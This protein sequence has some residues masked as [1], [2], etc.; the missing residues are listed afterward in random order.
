[1]QIQEAVLNKMIDYARENRVPIISEA[2]A[3]MLIKIVGRKQP[4]SVLEVGTAI[5]YSAILTA[6]HSPA[7]RILTIEQNPQRSALAA[8]FIREAGLEHRINIMTGDAG[9]ILPILRGNFDFVFLDAAKGQYLDYLTK[10]QDQLLPGSVV[11]ADNV[12]FRDMVEGGA[13]I[14][15]RYRTIVK[16]LR[17]Y[18]EF[19][20][21]DQ[22]FD[23][24]VYPSG[25]G[26]AISYIKGDW[27]NEKT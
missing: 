18:L 12:L 3:A 10:I 25:D 27:I 7:S 11:A 14:P 4:L 22:F 24:T 23:T 1:M 13:D 5:G 2:G 8:S 9:E 17:Q 19:V 16:R 26:M 15:R 6:M 21:N 20:R